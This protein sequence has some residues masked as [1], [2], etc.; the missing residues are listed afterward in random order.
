MPQVTESEALEAIVYAM[1]DSGGNKEL[2]SSLAKLSEDPTKLAQ[3]LS[4]DDEV[5]GVDNA[6]TKSYIYKAPCKV[7]QNP[8]RD[9]CERATDKP[10]ESKTTSGKKPKLSETKPS[11]KIV[12][13]PGKVSVTIAKPA[14]RLATASTTPTSVHPGA[15]H[16]STVKV[17]VAKKRAFN[18]KD[19]VATK[20]TLTKQETGRVGEAVVLAY[21]KTIK[22]ATDARPM[23][24]DKTNFPIDLIEDHRPTEVKAGLCS[25]GKDAQKWR[26]TFSKETASEKAAYDKMTPEQKT[27]YNSESQARIKSVRNL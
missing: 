21:L 24:T 23:N 12:G 4:S 5:D 14:N 7:G 9:H 18:G 11:K 8:G 3:Q 16:K 2:L 19:P 1:L 10:K 25:N 6:K 20:T 26:L 17:S 13:K 15:A 22:G 27:Q